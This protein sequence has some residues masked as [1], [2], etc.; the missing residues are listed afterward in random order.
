MATFL[1]LVVGLV[2][3]AFFPNH[4]RPLATRLY[5]KVMSRGT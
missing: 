4:I 1:A 3:G 5:N 2:V